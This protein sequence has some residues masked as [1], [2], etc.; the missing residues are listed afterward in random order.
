MQVLADWS[1]FAKFGH[2]PL[3]TAVSLDANDS[4][5]VRQRPRWCSQE[6][7]F[8]RR[9]CV[10]CQ[11]ARQHACWLQAQNVNDRTQNDRTSLPKFKM[12]APSC[13]PLLRLSGTA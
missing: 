12:Q 6:P 8:L 11:L 3:S 5:Y 2:Y 1:R 9:R 13:S 10:Q 7:F 4:Q